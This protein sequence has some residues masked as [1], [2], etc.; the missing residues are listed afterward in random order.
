MD[1]TIQSLAAEVQALKRTVEGL[2][3]TQKNNRFFYAPKFN[4]R[5]KRAY[6]SGSKAAWLNRDEILTLLLRL[7]MTEEGLS[8][9]SNHKRML[10]DCLESLSYHGALNYIVLNEWFDKNKPLPLLTDEQKLVKEKIVEAA[11][12][13]N[14]EFKGHKGV[15]VT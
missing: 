13:R 15:K 7:G 11:K 8:A 10:V 1:A 3:K 14:D 9:V 2:S 4:E 5:T 12:I 6:G